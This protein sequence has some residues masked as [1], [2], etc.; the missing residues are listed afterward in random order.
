[1]K[2]VLLVLFMLLSGGMFAQVDLTW[3]EFQKTSDA[4][5][6]VKGER[7]GLYYTVVYEDDVLYLLAYAENDLRKQSYRELVLGRTAQMGMAASTFTWEELDK[8]KSVK[9]YDDFYY[10]NSFL[11]GEKLVVMY[12]TKDKRIK[13]YY[14]QVFDLEGKPLVA[15]DKMDQFEERRWAVS[16]YFGLSEDSSKVYM[17]RQPRLGKDE[18][19]KFLLKVWDA[20]MALQADQEIEMPYKNKEFSIYDHYL[21]SDNKLVTLCRID[22]P[23]KERGS[24]DPASIFKVLNIDLNDGIVTDFEMNLK[25]MFIRD[26]NLQFDEHQ[27][28]YCVGIYSDKKNRSTMD[29]TFYYK[30]NYKTGEITSEN[31]QA[32][33]SELIRKLNNS[34]SKKKRNSEIRANIDLKQVIA[35]PDGGSF[36]LFEENYVIVVTT[37]NSNGGTSTTYYYHTNDILIMN[38]DPTGEILWQAVIPKQQVSTND[39]G[40]YNSFYATVYKEKLYIFMNDH[41]AN[42]AT[43]EFDK[44]IS[45]TNRKRTNPVML[46]MNAEGEYEKTS[47]LAAEKKRDYSIA[48]RNA[49]RV[50][51]NKAIIYAFRPKKGCCSSRVKKQDYRLGKLTIE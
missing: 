5:G 47:L 44:T 8:R 46:T 48:F 51:Q 25:N 30:L 20:D 7:N 32:F 2:N 35:K 49:D 38:I 28:A 9:T 39:Y 19:D 10:E 41:I 50:G 45:P 15:M 22:I 42:A 43:G 34:D 36:V 14:S 21:T 6:Y 4:G 12:Y 33:S 29:G 17:F 13:T 37:R 31:R 16:H 18:K 27:N 24:D 26:V 23:K 40:F 11:M 1:M 3:G